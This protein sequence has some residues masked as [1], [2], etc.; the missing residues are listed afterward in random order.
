MFI[1]I[2]NHREQIYLPFSSKVT[3]AFGK[4]CPDFFFKSKISTFSFLTH[5]EPISYFKSTNSSVMLK[6]MVFREG[7]RTEFQPIFFLITQ[8]LTNPTIFGKK[9]ISTELIPTANFSTEENNFLTK[10]GYLNKN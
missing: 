5:T 3:V 9:A 8:C 10:I 6:A 4:V 2:L 1:K 7:K